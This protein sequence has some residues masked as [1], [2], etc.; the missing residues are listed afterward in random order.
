MGGGRCGKREAFSEPLW[1]TAAV[2][3]FPSGCGKAVPGV[4]CPGIAFPCPRQGRQ[5]PR[6]WWVAEPI[7]GRAPQ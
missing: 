6:P 2:R 3:G 1:K 4:R 5:R 7:Q